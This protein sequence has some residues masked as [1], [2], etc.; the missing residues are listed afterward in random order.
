MTFTDSQP[1]AIREGD[2]VRIGKGSSEYLLYK[3]HPAGEIG[4]GQLARLQRLSDG[5][6]R[7]MTGDDVDRLVFSRR[8][9]RVPVAVT[10]FDAKGDPVVVP[11]LEIPAEIIALTTWADRQI[12]DLARMRTRVTDAIAGDLE[13]QDH[14]LTSFIEAQAAARVAYHV[15]S[16][17]EEDQFAALCRLAVRTVLDFGMRGDTG[18]RA[19]HEGSTH[20]AWLAVAKNAKVFS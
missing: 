3:L 1:D 11:P 12:A 5:T 6:D 4:L 20:E 13:V 10:R 17:L 9:D 2:Y 8:P 19:V 18:V 14:L 7:L 16:Y 15:K